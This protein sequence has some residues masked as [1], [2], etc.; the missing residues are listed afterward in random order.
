M[1]IEVTPKAQKWFQEE[2]GLTPGMAVGFFGKVYGKTAVHEGFSI[3]MNVA[4]A[5]DALYQ[6]TIDGIDYYVEKN[7]DWFFNGYNLLIDYDEKNDE[8]V[9]EFESVDDGTVKKADAL[10]SPSKK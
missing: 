5:D 3:G 7:D 1:K 10:S 8:P 6:T 4:S 9:Y 2:V